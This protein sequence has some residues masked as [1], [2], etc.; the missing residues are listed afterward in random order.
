MQ[1]NSK[2][3]NLLP[4]LSVPSRGFANVVIGAQAH[5]W[6]GAPTEEKDA[7]RP[8]WHG[9]SMKT[10]TA[11]CASGL[12]RLRRAPLPRP[13]AGRFGI[14]VAQYEERIAIDSP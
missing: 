9:V 13:V 14:Q 11:P 1:L 5:G 8:D 6:R 3:V 7:S 10:R 2:V 4:M 12:N